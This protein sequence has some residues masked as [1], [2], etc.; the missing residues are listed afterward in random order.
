MT[1][2]DQDFLHTSKAFH[3][4]THIASS[5]ER[6]RRY[7]SNN[8]NADQRILTKISIQ[9]IKME[10]SK[11]I[12]SPV[13]RFRLTTKPRATS[14]SPSLRWYRKVPPYVF[15]LRGQPTEC[16][17]RPGR[18]FFSSITQSWRKAKGFQHREVQHFMQ[19]PKK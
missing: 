19:Q 16:S 13:E 9:P 8:V 17:V 18:H 15:R 7:I 4:F 2:R 1:S 5:H 12:D 11:R 3:T 6:T 14:G 10:A